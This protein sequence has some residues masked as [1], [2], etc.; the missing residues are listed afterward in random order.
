MSN[1]SAEEHLGSFTRSESEQLGFLGLGLLVSLVDDDQKLDE[2]L[3]TVYGRD[4][5]RSSS[6]LAELREL[7]ARLNS[8]LRVTTFLS[9]CLAQCVDLNTHLLGT[10]TRHEDGLGV[11][12]SKSD[13]AGA[14]ASLE[15]EG[16]SLGRR[17]DERCTLD[18]EV[19]PDM[20]N[21]TD[22]VGFGVDVSLLVENDCIL[23]PAGAPELV[24]DADGEESAMETTEEA[25]NRTHSMYCGRERRKGSACERRR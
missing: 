1:P 24:E 8:R 22:A 11:T 7:G 2:N 20:V 25:L 23:A 18:L 15:Q 16:S 6:C 5:Q 17:L 12:S 4:Q 10:G 9:G 19:L 13:A 3:D 21:R 14:A